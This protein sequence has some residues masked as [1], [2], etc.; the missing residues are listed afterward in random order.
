MESHIPYTDFGASFAITK[1]CLRI[2]IETGY[3]WWYIFEHG[4][5]T[6]Q[7]RLAL[8]HHVFETSPDPSLILRLTQNDH[9]PLDLV[10]QSDD[11]DTARV[12]LQYGAK[13]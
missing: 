11:L 8:A 1:E 9:T 10:A 12:L 7:N 6:A 13:V 3:P 5:L 4:R 2:E